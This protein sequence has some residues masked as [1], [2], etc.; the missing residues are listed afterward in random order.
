ML[1]FKQLHL[2]SFS[3]LGRELLYLIQSLKSE[4]IDVKQE[5]K[6]RRKKKQSRLLFCSNQL[7]FPLLYRYKDIDAVVVNNLFIRRTFRDEN[8][9]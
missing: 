3:C 9:S 2:F 7:V 6:K 8:Q 4:H 1:L 5:E